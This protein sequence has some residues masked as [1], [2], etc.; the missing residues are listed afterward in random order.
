MCRNI[1]LSILIFLATQIICSCEKKDHFENAFINLEIYESGIKLVAKITVENVQ[2]NKIGECGIYWQV[3]KTLSAD[4][5]LSEANL[6]KQEGG[7]T[8]YTF[9]FFPWDGVTEYSTFPGKVKIMVT[10]YIT[11]KNNPDY[12]IF[13]IYTKRGDYQT[14]IEA[15]VWPYGNIIEDDYVTTLKVSCPNGQDIEECGIYWGSEKDSD[16]IKDFN[17]VVCGNDVGEFP[18]TIKNG[19]Y[20]EK[21]YC[22]GY[23]K[24]KFG[25]Y[26]SGKLVMAIPGEELT[27]NISSD[28]QNLTYERVTLSANV[29]SDNPK[30]FPITECGFCYINILKVKGKTYPTIDDETYTVR[31]G[32]GTF[33]GTITGLDPFAIYHVRA[34]AKNRKRISYSSSYAVV[35]THM[36]SSHTP[37]LTFTYARTN[38]T[39]PGQVLLEGKAFD[40]RGYSITERGF[41]YSQTGNMPTIEDVKIITEGVGLGSFNAKTDNL[42]PGKYLFRPYGINQAGVGYSQNFIEVIIP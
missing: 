12:K 18:V 2:A 3:P 39:V 8:T 40:D 22:T 6:I 30:G 28:L 26:Y 37:M 27:I 16:V 4:L 5:N 19:A 25:T 13:S 33:S 32:V 15:S 11:P 31:P 17:K 29:Y 42:P 21:M 9:E 36:Q 7:N 1:Y 34:Y 35:P 24:T 10:A 38:P 23:V 14:K 20:L 41:C